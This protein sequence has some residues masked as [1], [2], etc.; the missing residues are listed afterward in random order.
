MAAFCTALALLS[1]FLSPD[2]EASL[3]AISNLLIG[4]FVIWATGYVALLIKSAQGALREKAGLVDLTQDTMF[5][6]DT[7]EVITFW[8]RGAE[9]WR[10]IE[11][12][13]S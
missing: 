2:D 3:V 6:R 4:I 10:T 11:C 1:H 12:R 9:S 13:L 5:V 7:N 8:N